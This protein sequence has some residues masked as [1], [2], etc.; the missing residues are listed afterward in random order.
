[1]AEPIVLRATDR[2]R[3][4][5]VPL[6]IDNPDNPQAAVKGSFIYQRKGPNDEWSPLNT[7]SLGTIKK[8]ET[9]KLE[10]HSDEVFK[11]GD[12][13][14]PLFELMRAQGLPRGEHEFVRIDNDL[15]RL[16]T[17]G[18]PDLSTL[19][20]AH[21]DDAVAVLVKLIRW[22]ADSNR[23][24]GVTD[25][26]RAL[27]KSELPSV[28]SFLSLVTLK[29]AVSEWRENQDNASEDYWQELLA[30][31]ASVLSHVFSYPVIVIGEKTY[32]GGKRLDNKGGRI[33]DFL[34]KAA[35]TDGLV[36]IE[37]KTPT[38]ALLGTRYRNVYP[39]SVE[40]NGAIAQV[41]RYR[42]ELTKGFSAIA[43]NATSALTL[44]EPRCVIIAGN[45]SAELIDG[46]R[47]N[48]FELLRERVAGV[49]VLAFDELFSR[50]E[51][52][53]GLLEAED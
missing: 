3:L 25:R 14:R 33:S 4:I 42:Q 21:P 29:D 43:E 41:L 49:T 15:A 16:L 45:V 10:L 51:R 31:H 6:L 12:G 2:V 40:L 9:Y 26:L 22:L 28:T 48:S 7:E 24:P 11:L 44:G 34:A 35:L 32:L 30:K 53:I 18:G 8:G 5:F 38:T 50:L 36:I 27:A 13:L 46:E 1:M 37:I 52:S 47:K 20:D 39:L 19:L 17:L 23:S